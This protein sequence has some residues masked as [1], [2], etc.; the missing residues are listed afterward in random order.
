MW[1]P[2]LADQPD[3]FIFG[4]DNVYASDV[5]FS[6]DKLNAAYATLAVQPGFAQ[7]RATV[8]HIAIW[9]DHDYGVNDGG[10][11]FTHK[12]VSKEAFLRF[13][14]VAAD[15]PRTGRD[16][17]YHAY[18]YGP[19]AQRVQVILLDTRWHRSPWK[20][21]DQRNA[22]GKERYL[23]DVDPAKTMLGAAQWAWLEAQLREPAALR[24]IVSGIQVIVDGHGWEG[25]ANF[26]R[27]RERLYALVRSTRASGV[28][29]LS[30][31]RHIGAL[32]RQAEGAPYP[33]YELTSSGMTHPWADAKEAGPNRLGELFTALHFGVVEIDWAKRQ[34]SLQIKDVNRVVQRE[35]V[36]AMDALRV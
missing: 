19:L 33:M 23:P 16:G 34:V 31:D 32:Y 36:V 9:D 17:L 29:W 30:G 24:L 2:I 12:Q 25:W 35:V 14:K 10:A 27:E 4:G 13:W 11:E 3:L 7:L 26:P 6:L 15:D 8:P 1:A 18:S 5:P 22:P 28:I 21:T 20:P